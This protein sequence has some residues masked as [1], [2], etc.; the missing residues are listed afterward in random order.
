MAG[1]QDLQDVSDYSH[2]P[3]QTKAD[4]RSR[5][6]CG[7]LSVETS[8]FGSVPHDPQARQCFAS[9]GSFGAFERRRWGT[10]GFSDGVLTMPL[11]I[12]YPTCKKVEGDCSG[13]YHSYARNLR[14][15]LSPKAKPWDSGNTDQEKR[16]AGFSASLERVAMLIPGRSFLLSCKSRKSCLIMFSS[17]FGIFGD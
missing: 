4:F 5:M 7:P 12:A 2:R 17:Y 13:P 15:R 10:K 9:A 3:T 8:K 16:E 1:K 11:K 6:A 14:Q